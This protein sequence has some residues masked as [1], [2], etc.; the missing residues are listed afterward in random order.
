V[1]E[2]AGGESA[3]CKKIPCK[4]NAPVKFWRRRHDPCRLLAVRV[5]EE[6]GESM[7]ADLYARI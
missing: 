2:G 7:Y 5:C 1:G 4:K 6:D 3:L